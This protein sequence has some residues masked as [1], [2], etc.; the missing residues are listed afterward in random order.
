[1]TLRFPAPAR[2]L[3]Q[4]LRYRRVPS[5]DRGSEWTAFMRWMSYA[6]AGMLSHGNVFV[7][8]YAV[9]NLPSGSPIVEIGNFCGLS[10]NFILY[11]LRKSGRS[12]VLFTADKWQ[13]EG[14]GGRRDHRLAEDGAF[15]VDE[16]RNFV[17]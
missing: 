1:M 3:L 8:R 12:N 14:D 7:W 2:K 9:E 16:Y 5:T 13:F 11:F 4:V 6:N 10:T 17:R 15:S